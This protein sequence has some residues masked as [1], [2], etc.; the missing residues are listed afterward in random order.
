[1]KCSR[2]LWTT[3]GLSWW[4]KS[5]REDRC[6]IPPGPP[7]APPPRWD[8]NDRGTDGG[9]CR[10]TAAAAWLL[11]MSSPPDAFEGP[12]A[13][14]ALATRLLLTPAFARPTWTGQNGRRRTAAH[15]M[16]LCDCLL[17]IC[18]LVINVNQ[19]YAEE[20][21]HQQHADGSRAGASKL[22]VKMDNEVME[23][24]RRNF[25]VS[26]SPLERRSVGVAASKQA[27]SSRQVIEL[28]QRR[29]RLPPMDRIGMQH[30]PNKRG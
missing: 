14:R 21:T 17:F 3:G 7:L 12:A 6:Q 29:L 4:S 26:V 22:G 18:L 5:G 28:P 8:P 19:H 15:Q 25:P 10:T 20:N 11:A 27:S 9:I 24:K 13:A 30:L 23:P 16:Y 1:M 2:T